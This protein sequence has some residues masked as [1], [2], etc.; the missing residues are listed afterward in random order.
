M[1]PQAPH[2][3]SHFDAGRQSRCFFLAGWV[4]IFR[5][6]EGAGM[7]QQADVVVS[8]SPAGRLHQKT[9]HP[10]D[11]WYNG[12]AHV[13]LPFNPSDNDVCFLTRVRG[14]FSTGSVVGLYAA[15][16]HGAHSARLIGPI[17]S[18]WPPRVVS[19]EPR[20]HT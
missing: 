7:S 19:S 14:N 17:A 18:S 6:Y 5:E 8:S 3:G 1:S 4:Q 11:G 16:A 12:D 20:P 2:H 13:S 9:R 15:N 10:G